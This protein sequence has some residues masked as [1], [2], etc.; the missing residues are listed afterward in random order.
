MG[1]NITL[2]IGIGLLIA[3][4]L[5]IR[6]RLA[7]IH[8]NE[9]TIGTV[10]RIDK[11]KDSDGDTYIPVFSFKTRSNEEVVFNCPYSSNPPSWEVGE[12]ATIV[13]DPGNPSNA[14]LY[15]YFGVF[16]LASILLAAA[17]AFIVIGGGYQ[18]ANR[19]LA[20]FNH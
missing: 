10:I 12:E 16:G 6:H 13:Y 5:V 9:K 1:Y 8:S 20:R 14:K 17:M 18:I 3:S 19:I 7:F 4:I 11:V 15:T 2:L